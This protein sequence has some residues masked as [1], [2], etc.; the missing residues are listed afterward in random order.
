MNKMADHGDISNLLHCLNDNEFMKDIRSVRVNVYEILVLANN[1]CD[2]TSALPTLV[3]LLAVGDTFVKR[4][5]GEV[6]TVLADKNPDM[7]MLAINTLVQD[8]KD[9]NPVIRSLGLRL[10]GSLQSKLAVEMLNSVVTQGLEDGSPLVRRQAALASLSLHQISPTT[11]MEGGIWDSLYGHLSDS[12]SA[13][14]ASCLCSLEE[15]FANEKGIVVS[16]KLSQYLI[17]KLYSFTPCVQRYV[18]QFLLKYVPKSKT[19]VFEHLNALDSSLTDGTSLT[20]T[21]CALELFCHLTS[22]LPKVKL[23]AYLTGWNTIRL[24]LARERNEEMVTAIIDYLCRTNFPVDVIM[25]D[26]NK[27]FCRDDD[28]QFLMQ[29]KIKILCRLITAENA[30]NILEEFLLITRRLE[31]DSLKK[32]IRHLTESISSKPELEK[33]YV[34]FLKRLIQHGAPGIIDCIIQ[35]LAKVNFYDENNWLELAPC[36]QDH[37]QEIDTALGKI[38]L[39]EIIR[40]QG[41]HLSNAPEI[42]EQVMDNLDYD[43]DSPHFQASSLEKDDH[44]RHDQQVKVSLLGA[45][46]KMCMHRPAKIQPL[47]SKLMEACFCDKDRNVRDRALFLYGYLQSKVCTLQ[48]N[49]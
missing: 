2:V 20:I 8:C 35:I 45:M 42:L 12:D 39:L 32:M 7:V 31:K 16:N 40:S 14:V 22:D 11:V 30:D 36:I 49:S 46:V 13:T 25:Q 21:L 38:A 43:E 19:Q 10:L 3:K 41:M 48:L 28:S 47:L 27:F 26:F 9:V 44:H 6:L 5:A 18:L 4:V 24:Y 23:K 29:Q 37:H 15:I 17:S 1:G 34:L 33:K